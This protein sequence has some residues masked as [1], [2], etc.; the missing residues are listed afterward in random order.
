MLEVHELDVWYGDFQVLWAVSLTVQAGEIVA[1]L[2][3]N[4][5]GKSTAMN[6]ISGLARPRRGTIRFDRRSL[7]TEPAYA[8]ARVGLVHVLERRHVFPH[9]TVLENLVVGSVV[10]RSRGA[11]AETRDEVFSLF[12]V[13]QE[14]RQQR[15]GTL[16]GGEQQMVAI[17][18]G[19]MGRPRLLMLDEPMLGLSPRYQAVIRDTIRTINARGVTI[20]MIE[21]HVQDTLGVA[22]RAYVLES[23][24]VAIDGSSQSL[25]A[26]AKV[27]EIFMGT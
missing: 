25:L 18:R 13:L 12:P 3:P 10:P 2:G 14:R 7:E 26:S 21:Q 5:A 9:L 20:L 8:R 4:G 11:R 27:R 22:H 6:A 1:L 24:R 23:G 19:L 15:A 16:S 17:G